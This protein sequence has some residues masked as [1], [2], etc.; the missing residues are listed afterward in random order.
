M[1]M[2]KRTHVLYELCLMPKRFRV[3][4]LERD[5]FSFLAS[6]PSSL[7]LALWILNT[8]VSTDTEMSKERDHYVPAVPNHAHPLGFGLP[9][10]LGAL[11]KVLLAADALGI[12]EPGFGQSIDISPC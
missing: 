11:L 7:Y 1:D 4:D 2:C 12:A 5:F 3:L 6:L 8:D 10:E 9:I